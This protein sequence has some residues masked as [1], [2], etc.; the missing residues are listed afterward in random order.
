MQLTAAAPDFGAAEAWGSLICAYWPYAAQ[1]L[2]S[3]I[4]APGT[5]KIVLV[6]STNDPATPYEWAVDVS[7]Q[8]ETQCSSP[9]TGSGH[10]GYFFSSCIR[11]WVDN[12]LETTKAPPPHTVCPSN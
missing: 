12:Y 7:H 5:P 2:P 4:R 9:A 3:A 8:L 1:G 11:T 6:G 10:T